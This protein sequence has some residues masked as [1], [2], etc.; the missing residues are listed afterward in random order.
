MIVHK[1]KSWPV[2]VNK[3][4][5]TNSFMIDDTEHFAHFKLYRGQ[6][7]ITLPLQSKFERFCEIKYK[8]IEG[9]EISRNLKKANGNDWL[10]DESNKIL[11]RFKN[12][13]KKIS[14]QYNDISDID[15]MILGRHHGLITPLL[16]WSSNPLKALFFSLEDIYRKLEFKGGIPKFK[17]NDSVA[18]YKLNCYSNLVVEDEF[19]IIETV[20]PIG[21]RMNAQSGYFTYLIK[22]DYNSVEDYLKSVGKSDYLEK[23]IIEGESIREALIHLH[24]SE[25]NAFSLYPDLTG[26]ALQANVD[27]TT[28]YKT[29]FMSKPRK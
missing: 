11:E 29:Y 24:E 2:L 21:S 4:F 25:I 15:A 3:L 27:M 6:N 20:N 28:I 23:F 17:N 5:E 22:R 1:I 8:T 9:K 26:A 19:E 10:I 12:N 18:I 7:D 16:D 14:S 13:L